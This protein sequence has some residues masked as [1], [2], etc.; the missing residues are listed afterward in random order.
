M[1]T[2][3]PTEGWWYKLAALAEIGREVAERRK[4]TIEGAKM[5][6]LCE[7]CDEPAIEE[8]NL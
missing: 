8:I 6:L 1:S 3:G 4:L 2:P 7:Y 5:E